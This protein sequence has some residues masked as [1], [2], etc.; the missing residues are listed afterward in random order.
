ML[1][2]LE[3]RRATADAARRLV[4]AGAG[5]AARA[6]GATLHCAFAGGTEVVLRNRLEPCATFD[7]ELLLGNMAAALLTAESAREC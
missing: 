2:P 5:A 4:G 1:T 3:L 6:D 7:R